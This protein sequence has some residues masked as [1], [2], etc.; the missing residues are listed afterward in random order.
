MG[1]H[2]ILKQTG[3]AGLFA[4]LAVMVLCPCKILLS[5]SKFSKAIEAA[6]NIGVVTNLFKQGQTFFQKPVGFL[7]IAPAKT[8]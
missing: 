3:K 2:T 4:G 8:K 7:S 6:N 5:I 1:V